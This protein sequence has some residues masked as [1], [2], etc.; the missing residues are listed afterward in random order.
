MHPRQSIPDDLDRLIRAQSGAISR[1]QALAHG[2]T[3]QVLRRLQLDW[4]TLA[5]GIY[6]TG[7]VQWQTFAFVAL[8]RGGQ[9]SAL[10]GAAACHLHKLIMRAPDQL[11]VWAPTA[12][13]SM[14]FPPFRADF[15]R[16]E[17]RSRGG[18]SRLAVDE[19]ILDH[20]RHASEDDLV[21]AI[22]RAFARRVTTPH[23]LLG[24]MGRH[25]QVH[26]RKLI[27]KLCSQRN[28]GI[29]SV[30]EWRFT[31]DVLRAHGLPE[32][33]RQVRTGRDRLDNLYGCGLIVELDGRGFHNAE[34]DA[35]RDNR[36]ALQ[37]L[38][39]FRYVWRPIIHEPCRV[40]EELAVAMRAGGMD[41]TKKACSR[42]R[43]MP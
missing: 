31:E 25:K 1:Q 18:L 9:G 22:T 2:L 3:P 33:E 41:A 38:L 24:E 6:S 39:T 40:A 14:E 42:C 43:L 37:G 4:I 21:E 8:L 35:E 17:R 13:V 36:H 16:G 26:Q 27:T 34:F 32:P 7:D 28:V 11:H 15:S 19:A 5:P 20:A 29:E 12:R 10:G 23:R 30:L